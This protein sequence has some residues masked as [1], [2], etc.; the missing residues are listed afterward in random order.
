MFNKS[1]AYVFQ[2]NFPDMSNDLRSNSFTL[3]IIMR[4]KNILMEINN[5]AGGFLAHF[6]YILFAHRN[7]IDSVS[8]PSIQTNF[9]Q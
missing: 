6:L 2:K 5:P 4:S 7:Y 3:K 9:L 1:R 8:R